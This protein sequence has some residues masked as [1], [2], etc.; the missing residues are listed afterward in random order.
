V[1]L[2]AKVTD[3]RH[4]E[5]AVLVKS[6]LISYPEAPAFGLAEIFGI[7]PDEVLVSNAKQD[8]MVPIKFDRWFHTREVEDFCEIITVTVHDTIV[9]DKRIVQEDHGSI[10]YGTSLIERGGDADRHDYATLDVN[11]ND[12][13]IFVHKSKLF[14]YLVAVLSHI[15]IFTQEYVATGFV[16]PPVRNHKLIFRF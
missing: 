4:G 6:R 5:R 12:I 16:I 13:L 11:A 8:V 15:R 9:D 10:L 14:S 2:F 1:G 3:V 7:E